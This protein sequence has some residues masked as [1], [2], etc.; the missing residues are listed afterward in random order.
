MWKCANFKLSNL[1]ILSFHQM[2]IRKQSF[3]H[4]VKV[5]LFYI[6][7]IIAI[8]IKHSVRF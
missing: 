8:D 6:A 7:R 4:E 2:S 1:G 3:H 5:S